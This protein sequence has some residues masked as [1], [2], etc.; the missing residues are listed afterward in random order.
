MSNETLRDKLTTWVED[1][2]SIKDHGW[3]GNEITDLVDS[4]WEFLQD[5]IGPVQEKL[6]DDLQ[7]A[8]ERAEV[9]ERNAARVGDEL[10]RLLRDSASN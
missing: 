2:P 8:R 9:A 6:L 1:Y 4:L 3:T 10:A 5:N 7:I